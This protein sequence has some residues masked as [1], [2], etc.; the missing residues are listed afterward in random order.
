MLDLQLVRRI[1]RGWVPSISP[2][3]RVRV[4]KE[5]MICCGFIFVCG[6]AMC[7]DTV[8]TQPVSVV[9]VYH[10]AEL[11]KSP[12][13]AWSPA[14]SGSKLNADD[15]LRTSNNSYADLQLDP[16]NKFRLKENS[17]LK[18]EKLFSESKDA[19]GSVVKLTDL[20]LLRG[21]ILAKLDKLPSDTKLT[22][23]SPA[24]VAAV[25]GTAFSVGVGR[26]TRTTDVGVSRGV[27]QVQASGEPQKYVS[28]KEAQHTT[29]SP[30]NLAM[31]RAKGT[32]L[33]PKEMLIKRLDDPK[34]PLK[35][36]QALLER[37]K[38]PKPSLENIVIG[39][40]AKVI[41]PPEITD[42]AEAER[43]ALN[44][45]RYRAQK[46]IIEKL[47][48]VRLSGD[49]T[50]GDVMNRDPKLCESLLTS[51]GEAKSV[52]SEYQKE[53]RTAV[54]R[55]EF[56]LSKVKSVVGRDISLCWKEI[57]PIS[58]T[59][60]A[61][62]FGALVRASTE[63][64]ATVDAY[65]RLAEKIYGTVVNSTTTLKDFI[66]QNDQIEIA[67]KGVVQGAEEVSKTYYSD[68]SIDIVLQ[69]G[70]SAVR[71]A[72]SPVAGQILGEHYM[73]S[74]SAISA[75]DFISMLALEQM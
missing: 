75:D 19:N 47:E 6:S 63:R 8:S 58:L 22:L 2:T 53:E 11:L 39:G 20:G 32:G 46:G 65:R 70:G 41:A 71:Q 1:E 15:S 37:L 36:A 66:V 74:P 67:V 57:T 38:N 61:A 13:S 45:A 30:W 14:A 69:T 26:D 43:W 35:D 25:R 54:V 23:K 27:V 50:V 55:L 40:E 4:N 49:E 68:G 17:Q 72:V 60:Y 34:I 5:T 56:P 21:E 64:A 7:G 16:P 62:A 9:K 33:P 31:L 73:S 59:E 12:G 42:A 10:D 24:A 51:T 48:M 18:I 44:E 28:V 29:V 52:K 3:W